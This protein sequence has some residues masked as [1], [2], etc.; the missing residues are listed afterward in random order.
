M[1]L[2][3]AKDIIETFL[4]ASSQPLA[5]LQIKEVLGELDT[6]SIRQALVELQK[7]Y[8]EEGRNFQ[9]IEMGG[10]FRLTTL[11]KFA[12][13]LKKLFSSQKKNTISRQ[14]LETLAIIAYKQPTTRAEI[15]LIRGVNIDGV[16]HS[17]LEKKLIQVVGRKPVP[18]RPLIY[19]TTNQ[20][21]DRFGLKSLLDLPKIEELKEVEENVIRRFAPED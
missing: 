4:F 3:E 15:E 7:K 5:I 1:N 18:G 12:P 10:G 14:A 9:I 17:L 13:W 16:I 20:F 8:I 2:D 21:L 11:S 6:P 19:R